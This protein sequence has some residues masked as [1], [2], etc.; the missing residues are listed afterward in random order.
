[1]TH[2]SHQ[3]H[4]SHSS[5]GPGTFASPRHRRRYPDTPIRPHVPLGICYLSFV[6]LKSHPSFVL[7]LAMTAA[8]KITLARIGLIPAF[9]W[10]VWAYGGSVTRGQPIESYRFGAIALFVVAACM[11]GLDGFV[12]RHFHQQSR[13]G[14]ILDPI[15]D[16]V[17]VSAALVVLATSGWPRTFPVWFPCIVIG[18][19]L[20]LGAGFLVLTRLIERVEIRPSIA[21]KLATL[22]QLISITWVLF[23]V[24]RFL[25]TMVI[26]ATSL[27]LISGA[28]YTLDGIRQLR[29]AP[30]R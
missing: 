25:L 12:A 23:R 20:F 5:L 22:F 16:K 15:A 2:K 21:G 8:N 30:N 24:P 9:V 1:V 19:D 17:L 18:R 26:I 4:R 29:A 6:I 11:D 13:L 28:G 10:Q 14:A 27:T 3:S 7:S